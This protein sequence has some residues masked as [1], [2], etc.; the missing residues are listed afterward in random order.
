MAY[1]S[2]G[3]RRR[4][5]RDST[6]PTAAPVLALLVNE[7]ATDHTRELATAL[8]STRGTQVVFL[9]PTTLPDQT[10][11]DAPGVAEVER[12]LVDREVREANRAGE[13]HATGRV[14]VGR[15]VS[16]VVAQAAERIGADT[17]VAQA[18]PDVGALGDLGGTRLAR[19]A[20][21]TEADIALANGRGSLHDVATVSVPITHGPHVEPALDIA[22]ALSM[23]KNARV[24]MFHVVPE[25]ADGPARAEG[26]RLLATAR[27]HLAGLDAIDVR[28]VEAEDTTAAVVE[29]AGATDAVVLGAPSRGRL[30][31]LFSGSTVTAVECETDVPVVVVCG[32]RGAT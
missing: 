21:A 23:A 11:L 7:R 4:P 30:R 8:A 14:D 17:V 16:S 32:T 10:P 9:A 3:G 13:A 5:F 18:P 12:R 2:K 31:R 27:A 1:N 15:R 22:R 29:R 24:D 6:E 28:L 25:D 20:A 26:E 19:L